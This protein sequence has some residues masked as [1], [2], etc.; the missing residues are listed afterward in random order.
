MT[1]D[2]SALMELLES[3][4]AGGGI[5]VVREAL[6]FVLQALV[7]AEATNVIGAERYE[8]SDDRATHRNGSRSRVLS[9]KAGDVT[10][11]IP[12]AFPGSGTGKSS[13]WPS[14][15]PRTGP[16]GGRSCAACGSGASPVCAS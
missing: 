11:K 9:T 6:A 5:D 4:R 3:L 12:K 13:A 10:L 1:L 14:A 8:R 16:S 15:I 7:E 2:Q